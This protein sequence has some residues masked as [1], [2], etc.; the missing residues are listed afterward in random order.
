MEVVQIILVRLSVFYT[1]YSKNGHE[2]VNIKMNIKKINRRHQWNSWQGKPKALRENNSLC[3][4]L[5]P[6]PRLYME[7][8]ENKLM[9]P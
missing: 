4:T 9:P 3:T 8:P 5:S 2:E 6:H 7:C 1:P